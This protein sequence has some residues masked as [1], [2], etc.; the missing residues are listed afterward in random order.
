MN[1]NVRKMYL[2]KLP[3]Y[4]LKRQKELTYQ[5][6]VGIYASTV[7]GLGMFGHVSVQ[8]VAWCR[9]LLAWRWEK[10]NGKS[11]CFFLLYFLF[12]LKW[13][14]SPLLRVTTNHLYSLGKCRFTW[15]PMILC[16]FSDFSGSVPAS[17]G[18]VHVVP[19]LWKWTFGVLSQLWEINQ[20][21]EKLL[22]F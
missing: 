14:C 16:A 18:L 10:E 5:Y 2:K 8:S 4:F 13:I 22:V 1:R 17:V 15:R 11:F 19:G 3:K 12:V 21:G 7:S 9:V 6:E 20:D